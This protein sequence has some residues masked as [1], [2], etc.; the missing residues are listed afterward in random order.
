MEELTVKQSHGGGSIDLIGLIPFFSPHTHK[1][2]VTVG[3]HNE[4]VA[5]YKL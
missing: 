5:T 4:A 3:V 1:E 2:E